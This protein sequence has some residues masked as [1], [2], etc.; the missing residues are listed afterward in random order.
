MEEWRWEN[1]DGKRK[2]KK[3]IMLHSNFQFSTFHFPLSTKK[4]ASALFLIPL[5]IALSLT[6]LLPLQILQDTGIGT[7]F[8]IIIFPTPER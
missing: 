2:I 8:E 7:N 1:G 4:R 6:P 3:D 5:Y